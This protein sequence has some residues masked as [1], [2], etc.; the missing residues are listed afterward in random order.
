MGSQNRPTR[1][2]S[3]FGPSGDDVP[4]QRNSAVR[5]RKKLERP[6]GGRSRSLAVADLR[7]EGRPPGVVAPVF[8]PAQWSGP[9][10]PMVFSFRRHGGF[11]LRLTETRMGA[12]SFPLLSM[13]CRT[14]FALLRVSC[15]RPTWCCVWLSGHW[16]GCRGDVRKDSK[17]QQLGDLGVSKVLAMTWEVAFCKKG[18]LAKAALKGSK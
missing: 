11:C 2:R 14:E 9:W 3:H 1:C 4:S 18:G 13:A 5:E 6:S 17:Q 12:V 16:A 7:I 15:V 10:F 8:P